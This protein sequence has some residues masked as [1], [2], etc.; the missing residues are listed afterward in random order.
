MYIFKYSGFVPLLL[1]CFI[2]NYS[3]S[4]R[5]VQPNYDTD[6]RKSLPVSR[7]SALLTVLYLLL[8]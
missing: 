7:L 6:R 4:S 3:D 1:C 8:P 2:R 5:G